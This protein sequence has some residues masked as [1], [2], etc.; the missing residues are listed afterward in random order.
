MAHPLSCCAVGLCKAWRT[1]SRGLHGQ[2]QGDVAQQLL[3]VTNASH[4]CPNKKWHSIKSPMP[5]NVKDH[6]LRR[7]LARCTTWR[8]R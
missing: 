6:R 4:A 3:H 8:K 7:E 2:Q 5:L 1:E